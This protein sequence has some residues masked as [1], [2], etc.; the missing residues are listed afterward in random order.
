[1]LRRNPAHPA[2]RLV[3]RDFGFDRGIGQRLRRDTER[4]ANVQLA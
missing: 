2:H 4:K 1:V 3:P